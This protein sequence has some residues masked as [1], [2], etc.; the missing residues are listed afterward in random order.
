MN[1]S[2]V[3]R[4]FVV[5]TM[6]K[7][8]TLQKFHAVAEVYR[9][10]LIPFFFNVMMQMKNIDVSKDQKKH[11][12]NSFQ[13]IKKLPDYLFLGDLA[14]PVQVLDDKKKLS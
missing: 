3:M 4:Q 14:I 13:G 9:N 7:S 12:S 2:Q 8:L 10:Y 5:V 1:R 6:K 11:S